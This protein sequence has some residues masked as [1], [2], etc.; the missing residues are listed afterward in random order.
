MMFF[1]IL[2]NS[3][4]SNVDL[5]SPV[6]VDPAIKIGKL[7]NGMTYYIMK[8]SKPE[9][10]AELRLAVNVGSTQEN[11]DQMGLAHFTEHMAFNGTS[12]FAKNDLVDYIESIGSKFGADLN[13]YTSFDETVYM[14][15]IPTD[16]SNII[17]K[18]FQILEDWAH[19]LTF[20]S[21]E[22]DKERGVV[23]EEWRLGQGAQERMRRQYWPTLFKDSRY[24]VRLPIGKKEILQNCSYETLRSFY[25]D[26][27]RPENMAIVVIGDIDIAAMEN[28]IIN[29]FQ[30]IPRKENPRKLQSFSVPDN[31][32]VVVAKATDKEATFTSIQMIYKLAKDTIK[33]LGDYKKDII[34]DL[35]N[36]MLNAR[37][38]ELSQN[39]NPPF[40]RASSS[41]HT[42]VRTKNAYSS[43]A[44]VKD[45]GIE[46]GIEALAMEN[47]RV[48]QFGFTPTELER[49]KK[50]LLRYMEKQYSERDK[51]DSRSFTRSIV[52]NFLEADP[53]PGI[54]FEHDF[55]SRVIPS[56]TVED[57]NV[58]AKKWIN[59]DNAIV[60]ITAPDKVEATIPSDEK[61]K[62]ILKNVTS[63]AIH[64]YEDNMIDKPLLAKKP[65]PGT[66]TVDKTPKEFGITTW[67]L[68]NGITVNLKPT[69]FKNDE[70]SFSSFSFG[71]TSLYEEN[72]YL[73]AAECAS[74]VDNGG[75]GEFDAIHLQKLLAGKVANVSP[76]ISDVSQG[77][78]GHCSP[79]DAETMFQMIYLYFT[80]VNRSPIDFNAYIDKRKS[81]LQNR[82]SSPDAAFQDTIRTTMAQYDFRSRPLTLETL[83]QIRLDRVYD[84]FSERFADPN[85]MTF[86]FV[87]NFTSESIKP[88]VENYLAGIPSKMRKETFKDRNLNPPKGVFQKY[89]KKGVEPKS[90]VSIKLTNSFVYN[91]KNRND[92]R[93]LMNLVSIKLRE[94]MREEK[95]G[96]Y[97][98]RASPSMSH[99]PKQTYELNFGWGC[100]P[101]NVDM[102]IS[103][104]WEVIEKIKSTGCDDKDL[105]K[106]RETAIRE[107]ELA[108]KENNFWLNA[109]NYSAMD[110]ENI[111][112]INDYSKYLSALKGDDFKRLANQYLV[113]D[114]VATFILRP[115]K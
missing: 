66:I 39:P 8:N 111:A 5:N 7:K 12:H 72:D 98:V 74:I 73:N 10:R 27:Y 115:E 108:L 113:K 57:V 16:S 93:L 112:E 94:Q 34:A 95:S 81:L 17:D 41:Y 63:A 105:L 90:S 110:N 2:A 114:N 50:E 51:T 106:I 14:L 44:I 71:G 18:S 49:A 58:L 52:S 80:N 60:I 25:R 40:T 6:P 87:G 62:E 11:D 24:A 35:Y 22:I 65:T 46:R 26:W 42:L 30:D 102:L 23:T 20:D 107:R 48:K 56:I 78:N 59:E 31:K 21:I 104:M 53:I 76:F 43:S 83:N 45:G 86:T 103:T 19:N 97:G 4:V 69:E 77:M 79:Q 28:K 32:G 75:L 88:L 36:N 55:Y 33:T 99:Y 47:Q 64:P 1:G 101:E 100:A 67:K 37:L 15:Q 61:I 82:S 70:I 91:R 13:A 3:Q 9:H 84:I 68:S 54:E 89:V 29:Q 85:G 38:R 109:M 92:L 96:V